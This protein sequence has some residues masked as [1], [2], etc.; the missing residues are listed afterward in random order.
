MHGEHLMEVTLRHFQHQCIPS[1]SG[2]MNEQIQPLQ[3]TKDTL[4]LG[5]I[6]DIHLRVSGRMN[7]PALRLKLM[8]C[9]LSKI[10]SSARDQ[11]DGTILRIIWMMLPPS[12][13]GGVVRHG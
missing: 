11:G 10:T 2:I 1:E 13:D 3:S 7:E 8:L 12:R 4:H 6:R 5:F 9:R